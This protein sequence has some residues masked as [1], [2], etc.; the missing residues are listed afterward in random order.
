MTY[1]L[2]LKGRLDFFTKLR[3]VYLTKQQ[4]GIKFGVFKVVFGGWVI[5][6][7]NVTIAENV[8]KHNLGDQ[9]KKKGK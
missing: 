9:K 8:D 2:G 3:S 1:G 5:G 4:S 6:T 7:V